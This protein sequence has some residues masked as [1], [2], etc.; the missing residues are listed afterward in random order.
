MGEKSL[1]LYEK[2]A[3]GFDSSIKVVSIFDT[4]AYFIKEN[5]Q[6]MILVGQFKHCGVRYK[7]SSSPI[8]R[9]NVIL[10]DRELRWSLLAM[11]SN[12]KVLFKHGSKGS[13][14]SPGEVISGSLGGSINGKQIFSSLTISSVFTHLVDYKI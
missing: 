7:T 9:R 5:N 6:C 13:P 10:G 2:T 12:L 4:K 3:I 8:S 11:F 1:K 14:E